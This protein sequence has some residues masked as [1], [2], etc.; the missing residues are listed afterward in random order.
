M[1]YEKDRK[2]A[3]NSQQRPIP[4]NTLEFNRRSQMKRA[5]IAL[6]LGWFVAGCNQNRDVD[7]R[8]GA[9]GPSAA[10]EYSSG[11]RTGVTTGFKRGDNRGRSADQATNG[12][13]AGKQGSQAGRADQ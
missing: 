13:N 3:R 4:A 6:A 9:G 8:G 11:S 7:D 5:L 10:T 1:N 12:N 2:S